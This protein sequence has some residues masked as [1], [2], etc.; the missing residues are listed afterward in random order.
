MTKESVHLSLLF[1][2]SMTP[3]KRRNTWIHWRHSTTE[4]SSRPKA[5]SS[6]SQKQRTSRSRWS[7]ML[8]TRLR[9]PFQRKITIMHAKQSRCRAGKMMPPHHQWKP[10]EPVFVP[11]M[12]RH[13]RATPNNRNQNLRAL[14]IDWTTGQA[15]WCVWIGR[16]VGRMRARRRRWSRG[17]STK[18]K[19]RGCPRSQGRCQGLASRNSSGHCQDLGLSNRRE[20][21]WERAGKT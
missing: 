2:K 18:R 3:R 19:A 11:N 12:I 1:S 7:R 15:P 14:T 21:A 9:S 5:S 6:R 17:R 20:K 8:W 16:R 13:R 10:Q 4:A